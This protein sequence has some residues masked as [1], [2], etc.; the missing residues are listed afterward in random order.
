MKNAARISALDTKLT[1]ITRPQH[2]QYLFAAV[3]PKGT[4]LLALFP[5][6]L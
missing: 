2:I 3:A 4:D 5:E 6:A 1:G